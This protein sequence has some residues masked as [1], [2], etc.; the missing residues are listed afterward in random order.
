MHGTKASVAEIIGRPG[1]HKEL[2]LSVTL[3]GI[4][5]PLARLATTPVEGALRAEAVVEGILVTGQALGTLELE[6]ARCLRSFEAEV[7][8][9]L[10]E[11]FVAPPG[12]DPKEETYLIDGLDIDLEPMLR[13]AFGLELPLNPLCKKDC[14]GIC[15]QCGADLNAGTCDCSDEV[16]DPRWAPLDE[17]RAKLQG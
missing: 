3:E 4:G 7:E 14:K 10:C 17:L 1:I 8:T 6:C 16:L 15:S 2:P 12:G 5:G 11:L 9:E 13:D